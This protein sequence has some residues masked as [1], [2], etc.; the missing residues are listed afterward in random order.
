[1][2]V[3]GVPIKAAFALGSYAAFKQIG[4][5]LKETNSQK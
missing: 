3:K 2:T 1:V 5:T 4:A